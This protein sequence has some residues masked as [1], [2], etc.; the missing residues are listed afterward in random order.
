MERP[1][2]GSDG[3]DSPDRAPGDHAMTDQTP[4]P[5]P[6]GPLPPPPSG[7]PFGPPPTGPA[8]PAPHTLP[9]P[10]GATPSG[11]VGAPP[12]HFHPPPTAPDPLG[13]DPT[14]V[15]TPPAYGAPAEE[16]P[17]PYAGFWRR[18]W[19]RCIS[20][21]WA[22]FLIAAITQGIAVGTRQLQKNLNCEQI[23]EVRT[24][25]GNSTVGYIAFGLC[26]VVVLI[27]A[28]YT[29]ARRIVTD[30]A[31]IGMQQMG[32]RLHSDTRNPRI[33]T[34]RAVLRAAPL[35]LATIGT[36]AY[37]LVS[38]TDASDSVVTIVSIVLI[39]PA[40]VTLIGGLVSL[41]TPK[42][43]AAW[44]LATSTVVTVER[45]PSWMALTSLLLGLAIPTVVTISLI[46]AGTVAMQDRFDEA[47]DGS[48]LALFVAVAPVVACMLGAIVFGHLGLRATAW[49]GGRSGRGM[50][51]VGTTLGYSVPVLTALSIVFMLLFDVVT[52]RE[53][54]SCRELRRD[55]ELAADSYIA[56]NGRAPVSLA[57]LAS[58]VF[59][60]DTDEL[61]DRFE[62]RGSGGDYRIRALER[63]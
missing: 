6:P 4:P 11:P 21:L 29:F 18:Y 56:L 10:L 47:S 27:V 33:D 43:Q 28:H 8:V 46:T 52:D 32:L 7:G 50:A 39:L 60:L 35:M 36:L 14:L 3:Y 48:F 31:T 58:P 53:Q 59:D 44:D 19:A 1:V 62:L 23:G 45:E 25:S 40:A 42:R 9:A 17:V 30:G 37:P 13:A 51:V 26:V 38:L 63:C 2:A 57:D 24:C 41:F 49:D 54:D 15:A 34:S 5:G 12:T 55:I 22:Q 20:V 16:P 61:A